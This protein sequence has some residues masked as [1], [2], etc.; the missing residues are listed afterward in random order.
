MN[1]WPFQQKIINDVRD[2]YNKK[3]M[4]P[5]VVSP[6]GSGKTVIF[7]TTAKGAMS[8]GNRVLILVHRKEI[9]EQTLEK[10][11]HLGVQ[12]GQIAS[13]KPMTRDLIQVAMVNTIARRLNKVKKPDMIIADEAHHFLKTNIFGKAI[14]YF[15]DVP[16][17]GVT[18]T[19]ERLSGEGLG[20]DNQGFFDV[21][22]EGP[23]IGELVKDGY[24]SYP[25][26]YRPPEETT[27]KYHIKRGDFDKDEQ[28]QQMTKKSIVG[29]VIEHYRKYLDRLP[30]VCFCV[31]L[32]HCQQMTDS[33]NQAG[34]RSAMVY[35]NMPRSERERALK[36]LADGSIHIATSCDVISEGV[37]VPVMAG[38]ILLRRTL[39]LGLYLQQVGR[40]LRRYPGK[41][42]ATILDHC[43]NYYLHGHVLT[44]RN[45]SL[46]AKSRKERKEKP[47]TTTSCPK[48]YGVWPG[49]PR[50]CPGLLPSGEECRFEFSKNENIAGQQRKTPEVIA[51]EL[52]E[53]LPDGT[54][55]ALIDE[56]KRDAVKIQAMPPKV[57]QKYMLRRAYELQ[58][59]NEIAAL[60]KVIGYKQGYSD[61]VWRSILGNR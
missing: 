60:A 48:C 25:V 43:G 20:I 49:E 16:L 33:F 31:S 18:A 38:C 7:A 51:G 45:W 17:L 58:S 22:I 14:N 28:V 11:F 57:R 36:G 19:P 50:I 27:T 21:L 52:I 6:T 40:P 3:Y 8:K 54:P 35:G 61:F 30:V 23:Q 29:D 32:K 39:S 59:R 42:H 5:L 1:L 41:T 12:A 46:D 10:L 9:L 2:A 44:E 15:N 55:Q 47:P 4:A 53:A 56:L 37:D 34:Y 24:L 13:G 26:I